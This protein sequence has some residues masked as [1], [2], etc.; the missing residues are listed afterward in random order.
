MALI[1]CVSSFVLNIVWVGVRKLS[2]WLIDRS[3]RLNRVRSMLEAMEK[4]RTKQMDNLHE[5]YQRKVNAIRVMSSSMWIEFQTFQENYHQ[6]VDEIRTSY[7]RQAD[8]LR[9]YK[10]AQ[11]ETVTQHLD[12]IRDNY[13]QQVNT[14]C[15]RA[16]IC[17]LVESHQGLRIAASRSA[18]RKLRTSVESD[19]DLHSPI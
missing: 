13:N 17:C 6:Q 7:S 18:R 9:E 1:F 8:R 10:Q 3:E 16:Q 2:L 14:V 19:E 11:V 5:N 12:H 4:Y 15:L